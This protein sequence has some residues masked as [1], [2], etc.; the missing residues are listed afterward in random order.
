M[1]A[2]KRLIRA[3]ATWAATLPA[4]TK[5]FTVL[6]GGAVACASVAGCGES[7]AWKRV[8]PT[9]GQIVFQGKPVPGAVVTFCPVDSSAPATVRPTATTDEEGHFTLTTYSEFDGA[10]AGDYTV[11]VSWFPLV[12]AGSGPTRGPNKLPPKYSIPEQSPLKVTV[13]PEDTDLE[14]LEV[15]K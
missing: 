7:N 11:A 4:S 6:V 8:Y 12:D 14:T 1:S 13:N 10:P 9:T 5:P 15:K 2:A 3:V